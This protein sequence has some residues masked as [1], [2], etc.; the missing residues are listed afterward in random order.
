MRR[1]LLAEDD[2][3]LREAYIAILEAAGYEVEGVE[4]GKLALESIEQRL[5]DAVLLDMLMP[6]MGGLELLE[7]LN[8][9]GILGNIRVIAFTN[10]SD[11]DT[12]SRLK[13][14]GIDRYLLKSSVMPKDLITCIEGVICGAVKR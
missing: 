4:N 13:S 10:L 3:Y 9:R 12:L 6:V 14:F 7:V 2:V 8:S 1:V 5:P 11:E